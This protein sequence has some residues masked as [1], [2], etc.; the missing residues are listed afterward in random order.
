[1]GKYPILLTFAVRYLKKFLLTAPEVSVYTIFLAKE[2]APDK[3]GTKLVKAPD[4]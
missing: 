3:I 1:M 2:R 4:S